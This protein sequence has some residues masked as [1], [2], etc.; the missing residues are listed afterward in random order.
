MLIYFYCGCENIERNVDTPIAIP[1]GIFFASIIH[2]SI[3]LSSL[4]GFIFLQP[5][6]MK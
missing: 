3:N 4:S 5:G 2:F 6:G 1:K